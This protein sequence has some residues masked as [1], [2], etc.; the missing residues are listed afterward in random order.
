MRLEKI[1]VFAAKQ[2]LVEQADL[3]KDLAP[4]RPIRRDRVGR[5]FLYRPPMVMDQLAELFDPVARLSG[6][7]RSAG[8][9]DLRV[10]SGS[11]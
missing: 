1:Y 4:R 6:Q 11:D 8:N 2:G 3:L 9:P 5:L 10:E 7:N